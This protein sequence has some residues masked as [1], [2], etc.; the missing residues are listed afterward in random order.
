MWVKDDGKDLKVID[1]GILLKGF[2]S[3]VS[4]PKMKTLSLTVKKYGHGIMK[5]EHYLACTD[6]R[7]TDKQTGQKLIVPKFH[8]EG[9]KA[10]DSRK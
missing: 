3:W 8:Y 7:Q 9:I 6:S 10:A 1:L 4:M 5:A 2:I